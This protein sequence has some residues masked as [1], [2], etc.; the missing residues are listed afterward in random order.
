[1]KVWAVAVFYFADLLGWPG[2]AAAISPFDHIAPRPAQNDDT[3]RL[4]WL[5]TF[6]LALLLVFRLV[7]N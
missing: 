6:T 1:M 5:G 3:H 4:L 2:W 7:N